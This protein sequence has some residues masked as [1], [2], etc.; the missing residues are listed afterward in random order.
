MILVLDA[1]AL[2]ALLG[3]EPGGELVDFLLD[4]VARK[5]LCKVKF[6]R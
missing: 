5:K 3:R 1:C 4:S 6:I 2:I